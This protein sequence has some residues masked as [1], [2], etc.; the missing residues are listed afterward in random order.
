MERIEIGSLFD[1]AGGFSVA[2]VDN[3]SIAVKKSEADI[4]TDFNANTVTQSRLRSFLN[5]TTKSGDIFASLVDCDRSLIVNKIEASR[6]Y[7]SIEAFETAYQ[8]ILEEVSGEFGTGYT[9]AWQEDFDNGLSSDWT[10]TGT[11]RGNSVGTGD[12]DGIGYP[13]Y[14][15]DISGENASAGFVGAALIDYNTNYI[16]RTVSNPHSVVTLYFND[17]QNDSTPSYYFK[18]NDNDYIGRSNVSGSNYSYWHNGV[19]KD[20]QVQISIDRQ[21]LDVT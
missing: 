15:L 2:A 3:I 17:V 4:L 1:N 16:T 12:M 21:T 7:E 6:P 10:V 20:T 19:Q 5:I 11:L 14:S 8:S 18:I 13:R 9:V